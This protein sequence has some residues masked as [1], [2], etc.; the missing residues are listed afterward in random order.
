MTQTATVEEILGKGRVRIAVARQTACGHDCENCAGCGVQAGTI[1]AV[2]EDPV[3]VAVGDRVE[4]ATDNKLVI[5]IAALVYLLPFAA[6]FA[7][8]AAG[9][10]L[11]HSAGHALVTTLAT[12]A[13]CIPA[14]L[15]DRRSRRTGGIRFTIQRKL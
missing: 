3:G 11:G 8:Y 15:Y 9:S 14:V 5:G 13:G 12:G 1:R 7:G 10:L 6:F 2:A 4:V